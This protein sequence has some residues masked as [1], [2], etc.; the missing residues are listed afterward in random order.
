MRNENLHP[1][2]QELL[3][4]ADGEL[5]RRRAAWVRTHL[6]ACWDCRARMAEIEGTIAD[7]VRAHH[8][9]VDPKLPPVAGS[10]ALLKAQL[11][12]S[13]Q[14]LHREGW[15]HLRLP[16]NGRGLAYGCALA[17]LVGLGA[18][19]LFRQTVERKSGARVYAGLLPDRTLTP[20]ATRTVAIGDIC[21]TDRDEVI[22]LVSRTLQQKVF[23]EYGMR[24]APVEKYEVDYLITPGLGGADDIRNLWP[25]PRYDT[26]WNSTVK[27]QLEDHLHRL[28]CDGKLSLATAQKDVASDWISA[29]K[30]YF[31]TDEPLSRSSAL[32]LFGSRVFMA[33]GTSVTG[34]DA[35][36]RLSD[37][38]PL[39]VSQ[40][41]RRTT[42]GP[43]FQS[44]SW[45]ALSG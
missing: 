17:L 9:S 18:R 12:E 16:L 42:R 25:E 8:Q 45:L 40:D 6:A 1:S 3:L 44:P 41:Q 31:H 15:R 32:D 21:S 20:G 37:A 39:P 14:K 10:R 27:D 35:L 24:D 26:M 38:S 13:A 22:R 43:R 19:A 5:P 2:D 34:S 4:S 28:V 36:N 11:A 33:R 7:F 23:E 30:K 29:Y